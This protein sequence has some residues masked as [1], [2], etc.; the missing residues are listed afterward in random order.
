MKNKKKKYIVILVLVLLIVLIIGLSYAWLMTTLQGEKDVS[1]LVDTIDLELDESASEG[2]QLV[3]AIPTYDDD[4]KEF[5]PY[6]FSLTN[7]SRIDL[8]FS[9][10]LIDDEEL[11]SSCETTD[12]SACELLDAKD[13]R[14]E[15]KVG[16]SSYT[17]TLSDS[18]VIYHG[19]IDASE[20]L[21]C[22]LRVWLNIN[23]GNDVMG[24]A[25]L[26][27][28]QVF[29]TQ[30]VAEDKFIQDNEEVNEPKMDSNM[31]A[32]RHDGYNWVKT[33]KTS[34]WYNYGR[35]IW[36]NA[37]TVSSEK[38]AEYQS[39]GVGTVINMDDIET[40]W[41]WIP[42]Y[43]YTI[44]SSDGGA[45]YYGK[46]GVYL[47][48]TPTQALPGEIDIKFVGTDGNITDTYLDAKANNTVAEIGE[49]NKHLQQT[50]INILDDIITR[51]DILE[52]NTGNN[53]RKTK[54][55]NYLNDNFYKSEFQKLWNMINDKYVYRIS[56]DSKELVQ[57]TIKYLDANLHVTKTRYTVETG[58][59]KEDVSAEEIKAGTGFQST[60]SGTHH[61]EKE[62][63]FKSS[64][65]YDLLGEISTRAQITRKTAADILQGIQAQTF[66]LYAANPEEFIKKVSKVIDEQ[67]GS[68]II[69]QITY[70]KTS[71]KYDVDIFTETKINLE[72][73]S[74]RLK[75][76]CQKHVQDYL[77]YDSEIE[78]KLADNLEK[79]EIVK[80]YSKLPKGFL[81]PTPVGDYNPDWAIVF[82]E[83]DVKYIYFI[84]ET[85][86]KLGSLDIRGREDIKISCARKLYAA[87]SSENLKY[88]IIKDYEGLL[89]IVQG[90]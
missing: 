17:G 55:T 11:I 20:T 73:S 90:K 85:K 80:V 29:A 44:A 41:V 30:Q 45:N 63:D 56:F 21:D 47:S 61:Y 74:L 65:K 14:Y 35:G 24:K 60:V 19:V 33:D 40:M 32:V 76:K 62:K 36:A 46:R 38:L 86:G 79:E 31:I 2:I 22:E 3:N 13:I 49:K 68:L 7:K 70:Y 75:D 78:N 84:A 34:G 1:I 28:L 42:R 72:S 27:K 15:V 6:K 5:S 23:A 26:G 4:G 9:L 83:K 18:P 52:R 67:K 81:I 58:E 12:G 54:I 71:E 50:V 39:A 25:F 82:D 59:Q 37:V 64:V 10:S 77:D 88:D 16:D 8:Y 48:S 51:K 87:L 53:A 66:K 57:N 89:E 43:S 69:N